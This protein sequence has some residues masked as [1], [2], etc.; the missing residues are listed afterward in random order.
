M[1]RNWKG[2][3]LSLSRRNIMLRDRFCCQYVSSQFE[4]LLGFS[5]ALLICQC[6]VS[7]PTKCSA[8]IQVA[9]CPH[10]RCT[11]TCQWGSCRYC[12]ARTDLTLDHV[13]PAS[14]GGK[15]S[16]ENM[17]TA[18]M[19]CNGKKGDHSLKKLGWTLR[20]QPAVT[21]SNL[22]RCCI[23]MQILLKPTCSL[24][25]NSDTSVSAVTIYS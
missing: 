19:S 13:K 2:A 24:A 18:C 16:W 9:T 6:L 10:R 14:K 15:F 23:A 8:Y 25:Q 3:R 22:Q 17:V 11:L 12:G 4:S 20:K 1:Q 5:P 7:M 21:L